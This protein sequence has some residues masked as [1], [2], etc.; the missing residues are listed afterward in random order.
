MEKN[1]LHSDREAKLS[2]Q[3]YFTQRIMNKDRRFANNPAYV[4]AG[5]AYVEKKQIEG[6][7]GISYKRGKACK[8]LDGTTSYSLEDP[9][10]VLDNV[11]NTPRYWQKMRYELMARLIRYKQSTQFLY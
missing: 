9:Y 2:E 4:F 7:K 11:K 1:S 5:T 8:S 6:R 10:S 3:D